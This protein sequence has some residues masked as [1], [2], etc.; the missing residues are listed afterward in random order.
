VLRSQILL[1]LIGA[2]LCG[3]AHAEAERDRWNLEELYATRAAWDADAARLKTQLGE[4][5]KCKGQLG[6]SA[7]RFKSC[8]N[9]SRA[10]SRAWT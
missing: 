4:F 8:L 10:S 7:A 3:A 5:E 1:A 6:K 9:R 2:S